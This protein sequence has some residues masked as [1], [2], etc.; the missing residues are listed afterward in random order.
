MEVM[1]VVVLKGKIKTNKIKLSNYTMVHY[2][3]GL[4]IYSIDSYMVVVDQFTPVY[5]FTPTLNFSQRFIIFH[6]K[7]VYH[8]IDNY[9]ID[10]I[11]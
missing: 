4:C 2:P 8:I 9:Q 11:D 6:G 1:G 10:H 5:L 7:D 3:F